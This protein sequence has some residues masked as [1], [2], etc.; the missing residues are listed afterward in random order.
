MEKSNSKTAWGLRED[1]FNLAI[2][3]LKTLRAPL[4]GCMSIDPEEI[5][6]QIIEAR[7]RYKDLVKRGP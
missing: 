2:K 6:D 1:Q 5:R 7:E 3:S 4:G